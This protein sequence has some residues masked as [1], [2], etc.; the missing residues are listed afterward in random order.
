M[1]LHQGK[2]DMEWSK[3]ENR[4]TRGSD[5][6]PQATGAG[7]ETPRPRQEHDDP[8]SE[9]PTQGLRPPAT[10]IISPSAGLSAST[11][12][13][14]QGMMSGQAA[15]SVTSADDNPVAMNTGLED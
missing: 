6:S 9:Q 14:K 5:I 12:S 2:V 11:A 8:P 4:L 10:R 7:S 3:H 1:S 13:S 15:S